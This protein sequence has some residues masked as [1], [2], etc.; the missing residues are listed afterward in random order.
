M[1]ER[2]EEEHVQKT[3]T[4]EQYREWLLDAGFSSVQ[5]FADFSIQPAGT[6]KRTVFFIAEKDLQ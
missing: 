4:P 6:G 1:Y 2:S 5:V 3:F